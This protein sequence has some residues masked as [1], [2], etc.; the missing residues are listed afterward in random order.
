MAGVVGCIDGTDIRIV[1]PKNYKK[2]Y[3]YR[4]NYHSL[5]VQLNLWPSYRFSYVILTIL[6]LI[7]RLF[8]MPIIVSSVYFATKPGYCHDS[9]I[10]K[11]V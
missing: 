7:F 5:N 6:H 9:T 4:K 10:F 1:K 8:V 11:A 2:A 3:V